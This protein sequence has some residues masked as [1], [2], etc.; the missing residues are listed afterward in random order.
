M[1]TYV[2]TCAYL[3]YIHTYIHTNTYL[4]VSVYLYVCVYIYVYVPGR[5]R[6]GFPGRYHICMYMHRYIYMYVHAPVALD[7]SSAE[8]PT[9]SPVSKSGEPLLQH[10]D[11]NESTQQ[12][13]RTGES[14]SSYEEQGRLAPNSKDP[15][16]SYCHPA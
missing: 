1:C 7:A 15:R 16:H 3:V 12:L 6:L 4:C 8:R 11:R 10:A 14:G 5:V 2:Y 9:L 13:R